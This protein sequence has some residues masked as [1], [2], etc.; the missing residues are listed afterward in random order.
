LYL[1]ELLYDFTINKAFLKRNYE[2]GQ[3]L[4]IEIYENFDYIDEPYNLAFKVLEKIG[5]STLHL[6]NI[7][8]MKA[9]TKEVT[10]FGGREY[11]ISVIENREGDFVMIRQREEG[12]TKGGLIIPKDKFVEFQKR[13]PSKK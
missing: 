6:S 1:S 3:K 5:A 13:W 10:N 4:I 11:D 9:A 2:I 8:G 7:A 12:D